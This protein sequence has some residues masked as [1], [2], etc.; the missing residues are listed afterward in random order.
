M[1]SG[2]IAAFV[3]RG[4][5]TFEAACAGVYAHAV[6]GREAARRFG[7]ESVVAG[8]VIDALPTALGGGPS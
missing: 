3:A 5:D 2:V 6:A 1:L 7:A 8:D 4:L